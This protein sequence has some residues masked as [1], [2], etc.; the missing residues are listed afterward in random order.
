LGELCKLRAL[1]IYFKCRDTVLT[2][3]QCDLTENPSTGLVLRLHLFK[4]SL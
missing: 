3:G 4:V 1:D 2:T